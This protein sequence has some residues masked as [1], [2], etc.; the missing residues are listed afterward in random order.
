MRRNKIQ[1]AR[2]KQIPK[3]IFRIWLLVIVWSLFLVPCSFAAI[4][5]ADL[6]NN[7]ALYDG[8][9]IDYEGELIG[10]IMMRGDYAW[11][12]I[13]DGNYAIGVFIDK[14]LVDEKYLPG[15]YNYKGDTVKIKGIFNRACPEH[16]GDLDIHAST[17]ELVSPGHKIKHPLNQTKIYIAGALL[18]G[19]FLVMLVPAIIKRFSS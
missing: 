1:D 7:S 6:I 3:L 16:G 19:I 9:V 5:S 4:K 12:N 15:N 2:Y 18:L 10:D 14:A 17:I 11:I 8:Q 13:N